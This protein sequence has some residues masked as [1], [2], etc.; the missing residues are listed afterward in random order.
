MMGAR[1]SELATL[2]LRVELKGERDEEKSKLVAGEF[3]DEGEGALIPM[4]LIAG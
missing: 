1:E 3:E 4:H 2:E